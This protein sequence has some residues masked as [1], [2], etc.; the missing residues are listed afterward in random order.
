MIFDPLIT[1]ITTGDPLATEF[2]FTVTLAVAS[3]TVGVS[4]IDGV[5]LITPVA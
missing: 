5:V 2:P 4:V 1:V 3:A